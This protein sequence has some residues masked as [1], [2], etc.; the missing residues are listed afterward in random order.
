MPSKGVEHI[1]TTKL[2]SKQKFIRPSPESSLSGSAGEQ[3]VK[4]DV[5]EPPATTHPVGPPSTLPPNVADGPSKKEEKESMPQVPTL[6]PLPSTLLSSKTAE[7]SQITKPELKHSFA[8]VHAIPPSAALPESAK[9]ETSKNIKLETPPALPKYVE[10]DKTAK[11][12]VKPIPAAVSPTR[13]PLKAVE[14]LNQMAPAMFTIS[15]IE[16]K[17]K[18]LKSE[19]FLE[20]PASISPS[21]PQGEP[22]DKAKKIEPSVS[23][24]S[25]SPHRPT[26]LP[27]K[28]GADVKVTKL[29]PKQPR[30]K[31]KELGLNTTTAISPTS[32]PSPLKEKKM[33]F[34]LPPTLSPKVMKDKKHLKGKVVHSPAEPQT[35]TP[36]VMPTKIEEKSSKSEPRRPSV[37]E[38]MNAV[39][40]LGSPQDDATDRDGLS[41]E[42]IDVHSVVDLRQ[43]GTFYVAMPDESRIETKGS[44]NIQGSIKLADD[45]KSPK[46]LAYINVG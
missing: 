20:A 4:K 37:V 12:E 23:T 11:V 5:L 2:E 38:E 44:T 18:T 36:V 34:E 42:T 21:V 35:L 24:K 31:K 32:L 29:K 25:Q 33:K 8:K 41:L 3:E 13:V 28:I 19:Q 43:H 45:G 39:R 10:E 26:I 22:D 15:E 17:A 14:V 46:V 27:F 9:E 40:E 7:V 16:T 30:A 6:K 1:N